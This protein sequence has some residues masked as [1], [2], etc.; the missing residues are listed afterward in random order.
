VLI[1][2]ISHVTLVRVSKKAIRVL[3]VRLIGSSKA[4]IIAEHKADD[5]VDGIM[6][7]CLAR[8]PLR[9]QAVQT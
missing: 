7:N 9:S 2:V 1:I 8:S 3:A 6:P 5:I 4:E